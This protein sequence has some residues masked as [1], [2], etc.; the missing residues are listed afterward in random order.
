MATSGLSCGTWDL[1]CRMWDPL[2]WRTGSLSQCTGFSLVV[3]CGF[4]LSS[5]GVRAPECMGSVVVACGLS[6]CGMCSAVVALGLSCPTAWGILVPR[7]GI[8]PV[9]PALEGGLLTTREVPKM[10]LLCQ[11]YCSL[12]ICLTFPLFG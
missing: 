11:K 6:S 2:L 1:R 5:C 8:E 7:P 12:I 10:L 4:S 9:S 3:V